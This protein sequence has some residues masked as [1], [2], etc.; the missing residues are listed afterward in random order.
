M[1]IEHPGAFVE[2]IPLLRPDQV[3]LDCPVKPS[4]TTTTQTKSAAAAVVVSGLPVQTLSLP[5]KDSLTYTI[6]CRPARR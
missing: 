4:A 5:G 3:E 6:R 2:Q 1:K